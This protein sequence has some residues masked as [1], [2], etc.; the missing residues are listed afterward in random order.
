[1]MYMAWNIWKER[2]RRIFDAKSTTSRRVLQLI[3]NEIVMRA[4]A[5]ESAV[6]QVV[7]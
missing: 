3:Q 4:S 2:N 7:S 1:M 6:Q 5:C